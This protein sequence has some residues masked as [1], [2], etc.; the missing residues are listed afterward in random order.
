MELFARAN[1]DN[2][3][4][5][6]RRDSLREI[7]NTHCRDL[8]H[9]HL[10][11]LHNLK[12]REDEIYGLRQ[13]GPETRHSIISDREFPLFHLLLKKRYDTAPRTHD[14][15]VPHNTEHGLALLASIRIGLNEQTIGAQFRGAVEIYGACGFVSRECDDT[16]NI[17]IESGINDVHRAVNIGLDRF[18]R[19]VFAGRHL[20][21]RSRM[22]Y[23]VDT[24]GSSLHSL[25]IT[26]ITDEKTQFPMIAEFS[27]HLPLFE[28]V[29]TKNTY[30]FYIVLL[31]ECCDTCSAKRPCSARYKHCFTIKIAPCHLPT[32]PQIE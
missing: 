18:H 16:W 31:K 6:V 17:I 2:P 21:Q 7:Q 32:V 1:A 14:I 10:A 27:A 23:D 29:A 4:C 19:I 5:R 13:R 11:P 12:G 9:E 26:H 22:N 24:L 30:R 8:R 15:S 3:A 25:K 20:L 28:L